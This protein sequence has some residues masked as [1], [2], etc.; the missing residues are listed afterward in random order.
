MYCGIVSRRKTWPPHSI[1]ILIADLKTRAVPGQMYHHPSSFT[2]GRL[3]W[4][5]DAAV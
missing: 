5:I 3:P 1:D 4:L 2:R